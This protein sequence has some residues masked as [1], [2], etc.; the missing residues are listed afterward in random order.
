L[1][2]TSRR[3]SGASVTREPSAIAIAR[4]AVAS[5]CAPGVSATS[6]ASAPLAR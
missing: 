5:I 4:G 1:A 6:P 3:A 2:S